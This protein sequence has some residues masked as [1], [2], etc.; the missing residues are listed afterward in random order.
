ML[1]SGAHQLPAQAAICC[2]L[3]VLS[4]GQDMAHAVQLAGHALLTVLQ[5]LIL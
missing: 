3:P 5:L 2:C 1:C 4:K